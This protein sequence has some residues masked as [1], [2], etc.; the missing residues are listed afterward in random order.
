[1][2]LVVASATSLSLLLLMTCSEGSFPTSKWTISIRKWIIT[3][4]NAKFL[5]KMTEAHQS[6]RSSRRMSR[7]KQALR[8]VLQKAL[9]R[10]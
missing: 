7:Q 4:V 3:Q 8:H 6:Y 10:V 1:M 5:D 9:W 2:V